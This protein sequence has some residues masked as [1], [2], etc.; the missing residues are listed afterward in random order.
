[1][2]QHR[3]ENFLAREQIEATARVTLIDFAFKTD[4]LKISKCD[5]AVMDLN[6]EYYEASQG[7]KEPS[8]RANK[9]ESGW[10]R[11]LV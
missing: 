7:R 3:F 9:F 8:P 4:P 1:M 11:V 2:Q 6:R 10:D 5:F